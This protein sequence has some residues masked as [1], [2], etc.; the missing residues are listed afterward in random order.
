MFTAGESSAPQLHHR[1]PQLG[2]LGGPGGGR[3]REGERRI[4]RR[5]VGK[6]E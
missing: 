5:G 6:E 2:P 1:G 3:G 4:Q